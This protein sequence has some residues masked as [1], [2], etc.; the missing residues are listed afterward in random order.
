MLVLSEFQ[1]QPVVDRWLA[2]VGPIGVGVEDDDV[3][4]EIVEQEEVVA[5]LG[6]ASDAE[7]PVRLCSC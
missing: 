5:D 7:W 4:P 3:R 6:E 2:L 1:S